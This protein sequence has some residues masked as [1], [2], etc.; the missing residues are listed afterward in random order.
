MRKRLPD[1]LRKQPLAIS[2]R[3]WAKENL[4]KMADNFSKNFGK[5]ITTGAVVELLLYAWLEEFPIREFSIVERKGNLTLIKKE[6][7]DNVKTE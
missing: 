5:N 3:G 1:H 2:V 7:L 6:V 4:E